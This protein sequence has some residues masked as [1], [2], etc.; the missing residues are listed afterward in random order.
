MDAVSDDLLKPL[1]L[2]EPPRSWGLRVPFNFVPILAALIGSAAATVLLAVA[3]IDDPLGG[4]PSA[5]ATIAPAREPQPARSSAATGEAPAAAARPPQ[6]ASASDVESASGVS[7]VRATGPGAPPE[8]VIIRVPESAPTALGRAPDPR[9][10][11][12]TRQ[13]LLPRIGKDGSRALS[14]YARPPGREAGTAQARIALVVTGLGIGQTATA[15][16]IAKL[17]PAVTLAFAPYGAD[18]EGQVERAREGGHEVMLQAPMEPF[19]YPDNDPG[20]H[21]LLTEGKGAETSER[22]HWIM[23]RFPGYIGLVNFMGAKLMA[24][25]A[26]LAKLLKEVGARGLGFVDDGSSPRSL[27]ASVGPRT[28]TPTARAD[29]V[30][31]AVPRAEAIE[32]ELTRLEGLA[33]SK[34]VAVASASALPMTVERIASWAGTLERKGIRLVPVSSVL[35][36]DAA[37]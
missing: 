30:L 3:F 19:D 15:Q 13:G 34:G 9:L 22:L 32:R 5:V 26:A 36:A 28:G 14:V 37:R 1:G 12:R 31:D 6:L 10:V 27:A 8:A 2:S 24:N 18:L 11:E 21:T 33:K 7:V 16:A 20:P 23:S 17:P 4:Q 35:L 25:E 29:A